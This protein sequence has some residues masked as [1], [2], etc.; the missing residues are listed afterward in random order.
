MISF[1]TSLF[2]TWNENLT[3]TFGLYVILALSKGCYS[4]IVRVCIYEIMSRLLSI[5][6]LSGF[7]ICIAC[8]D[9]FKYSCIFHGCPY[10]TDKSNLTPT[11]TTFFTNRWHFFIPPN[12]EKNIRPN[13]VYNRSKLDFWGDKNED[14]WASN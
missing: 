7:F 2:L 14:Y 4:F 10:I 12:L 13:E 8:L 6:F 3:M 11:T 1:C 9:C 5:L